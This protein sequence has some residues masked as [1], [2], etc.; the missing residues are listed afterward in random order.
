MTT[1]I[2]LQFSFTIL[3]ICASS[4]FASGQTYIGTSL[5]RIYQNT[6]NC[7][8]RINADSSVNF[9]YDQDGNV[10]YGEY[11]G[12]ISRV[13]D[14]IFH[15]AAVQT[16]G[17][18]I[19]KAH[20]PGSSDIGLDSAI[21]QQLGLITLTYSNG[22]FTRLSSCD[23]RGRSKSY[24][25]IPANK[26]LFNSTKGTD[27]F[28]LTI[29][30]KHPITGKSLAFKI[31]YFSEASFTSGEKIDFDVQIKN[32][33]LWTIGEPPLQIGHFKLRKKRGS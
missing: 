8:L 30:R 27:Y 16:L 12:T 7:Q 10:V 20:R 14:S 3:A 29:P 17:Q 6:Y 25:K 1:K 24:L 23:R 28:T 11:L 26:E 32:G 5:K 4:L 18:D 9:I 15:I 2:P 31:D 33:V 22:V 21:A 13:N 19:R